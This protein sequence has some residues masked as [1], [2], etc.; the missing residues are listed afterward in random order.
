MWSC[1]A[2]SGPGLELAI[3]VRHDDGLLGCSWA[4]LPCAKIMW[5]KK[6]QMLGKKI[7]REMFSKIV[8]G[9]ICLKLVLKFHCK[10][11]CG[12]GAGRKLKTHRRNQ[13]W[14]DKAY[15]KSHLG[16]EWKKPFAG[17]SHAK[18]IVL[19]KMY[20]WTTLM[21]NFITHAFLT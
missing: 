21:L 11:T 7:T 14:A 9:S 10:K 6:Y 3:R 2:V 4:S 19:E 8:S 17:S 1:G 15:K 20:A 12:M 13:R 16:N 5:P 18:G